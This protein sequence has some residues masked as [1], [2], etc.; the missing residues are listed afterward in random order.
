M[1]YDVA[2]Q[3]CPKCGTYIDDF[4][5]SNFF[6]HDKYIFG[7]NKKCLRIVFFLSAKYH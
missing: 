5:V 6:N 1:L 2:R 4:R 7:K 3:R